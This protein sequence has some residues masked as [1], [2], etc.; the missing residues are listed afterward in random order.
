MN[1]PAQRVTITDVQMPFLSMV[2]F[3]FKWTLASIPAVLLIMAIA[4]LIATMF[5]GL[6]ALIGMG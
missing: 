4:F 3:I 5:G 2:V 6:G 1:E